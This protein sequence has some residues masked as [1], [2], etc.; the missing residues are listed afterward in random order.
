MTTRIENSLIIENME[1][2]YFNGENL[3]IMKEKNK[4]LELQLKMK[5]L[6]LMSNDP[7]LFKLFCR[8][9]EKEIEFDKILYENPEFHN[10]LIEYLSI[11]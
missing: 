4:S 8:L 7:E 2:E 3:D 5:Q 9:K 11:Q 10:K 1:E 6:D